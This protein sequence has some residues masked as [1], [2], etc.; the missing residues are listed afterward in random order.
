[1]AANI[2]LPVFPEFPP[3]DPV[4]GTTIDLYDG[5]D[6]LRAPPLPEEDHVDAGLEAD[7]PRNEHDD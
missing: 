1:M 6:Q 4:T 5:Y 7:A 3:H 2:P